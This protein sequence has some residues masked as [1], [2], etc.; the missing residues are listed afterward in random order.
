MLNEDCIL[1]VT[2]YVPSVQIFG[3]T[4]IT[5]DVRNVAKIWRLRKE[6]S[7]NRDL[8]LD[9]DARSRAR[10]MQCVSGTRNISQIRKRNENIKT[11]YI[12]PSQSPSARPSTSSYNKTA[13]A[14]RACFTKKK[15]I[16]NDSCYGSETSVEYFRLPP[17]LSSSLSSMDDCNVAIR[18]DPNTS[19]ES[20]KSFCS[21]RGES[22]SSSEKSEESFSSSDSENEDS[23]EEDV[24]DKTVIPS[25]VSPPHAGA[26]KEKTITLENIMT[27]EPPVEA[28]VPA[29]NNPRNRI[30]K[31]RAPIERIK[32]QGK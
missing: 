8:S 25:I 24:Q 22:V 5:K 15:T 3:Q 17:I 10:R 11:D 31:P 21:V 19:M 30:Q 13:K 6:F 20:N 23:T 14:R 4:K 7:E 26:E 9:V 29:I 32:E 18:N 28:K 12:F 1:F 2:S 16:S 27:R